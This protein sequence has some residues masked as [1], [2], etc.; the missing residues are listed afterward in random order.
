LIANQI[1]SKEQAMDDKLR[2]ILELAAIL[3]CKPITVYRH[4]KSGKIPH[5]RVGKFIRFSDSDIQSY[6]ES[7]KFE[8]GGNNGK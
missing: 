2:T 6:L 4:V 5:R 3:G 8:K 1:L 7:V